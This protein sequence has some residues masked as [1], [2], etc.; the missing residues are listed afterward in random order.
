[1]NIP[2]LLANVPDGWVV[3]LVDNPGFNEA[4]KKHIQQLAEASVVS[5]A[6]YIFLTDTARMGNTATAD[7]FR[8]LLETDRGKVMEL[9]SR[10][11]LKSSL[12]ACC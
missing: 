2:L 12:A 7:F 10:F 8:K 6:A 4:N 11:C 5:S 3:S 9:V 1:M